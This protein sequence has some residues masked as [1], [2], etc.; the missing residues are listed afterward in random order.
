SDSVL[1]GGRKI[2]EAQGEQE[3]IDLFAIRVVTERGFGDRE[4][5]QLEENVKLYI[6]DVRVDVQKVDRIDRGSSGKF[7]AVRCKL[8]KEEKLPLKQDNIDGK[9]SRG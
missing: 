8:T 4:E 6:G 7:E 1:K 9:R 5:R 3:A 2:R